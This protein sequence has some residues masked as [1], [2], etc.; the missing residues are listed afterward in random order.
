MSANPNALTIE[1]LA[2]DSS[3]GVIG[4][5]TQNLKKLGE[6]AKGTGQQLEEHSKRGEKGLRSLFHTA[7]IGGVRMRDMRHV[8]V[9]A[10]AGVEFALASMGDKA[11]KTTQETIK[12]AQ[13]GTH[14]ALAFAFGGPIG[15]G[16][17]GLGILFGALA[18]HEAAVTKP[19]RDVVEALN[20]QTEAQSKLGKALQG[21]LPL[22]SQE[23]DEWAKA[24]GTSDKVTEPLRKQA[25]A[26]EEVN[27]LQNQQTTIGPITIYQQAVWAK[28]EEERNHLLGRSADA[29]RWA[30]QGAAFL[31]QET[32]K[33]IDTENEQKR[34]TDLLGKNMI[35]LSQESTNYGRELA[36]LAREHE[37]NVRGFGRDWVAAEHRAAE[38]VIKVHA[39]TDQQI[40]D[41]NSRMLQ[42]IGDLEENALNRRSDEY[43]SYAQQI[44][45]IN[46]D[47]AR[48]AE[49]YQHELTGVNQDFMEREM[50]AHTYADVLR[51]RR[52]A[53]RRREELDF[54]KH[55]QDEDINYRKQ[56]EDGDYTHKVEIG[57]RDLA[58]SI[59]RAQRGADEQIAQARRA[60][61][62]QIAATEERVKKEQDA[63]RQR[64]N[65]ER[66]AYK[67]QKARAGEAH[68]ERVK[69]LTDIRTEE[70]KVADAVRELA[71]SWDPAIAQAAKYYA[72]IQGI[73][74][75]GSFGMFGS[76]YTDVRTDGGSERQHG[77]PVVARRPYMVGER[78]PELFVPQ[79]SGQIVSNKDLRGAG[80]HTF[81]FNAPIYGVSD[82]RS[83]ILEALNLRDRGL[84]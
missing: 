21:I 51:I 8:A 23:A 19:S 57:N 1:I 3:A 53:G 40:I 48:N 32:Q 25:A 72:I 10:I 16:L 7:E 58:L 60:E 9:G 39:H 38:E 11:D 54:K 37:K 35:S 6:E 52:E 75:G 29:A 71:K 59:S 61:K 24:A 68:A 65:D 22:T 83:T 45:D 84:T 46:R 64:E 14:L 4:Q 41:V 43:Y 5:T 50:T 44:N 42:Q 36:N 26:Q 73:G 79:N 13:T 12:L 33:L 27:R 2:K 74:T 20:N 63:I 78:G 69:Q 15:V 56:K 82:L 80:G 81:N 30:A 47:I 28:T 31:R 55:Q 66:V 76:N 77:G 67:E 34:V 18:E 17:A 70:Q 62:E 49:N